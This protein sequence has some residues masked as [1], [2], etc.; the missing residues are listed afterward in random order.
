MYNIHIEGSSRMTKAEFRSTLQ[1][2]DGH[3]VLEMRS[4]FSLT[5]EWAAH[6]ALFR[7]GLWKQRTESVDL[8]APQKWWMT[9][10][11]ILTGSFVWPFIK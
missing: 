7:L 6:K 2:W 4:R 3:P 1:K 5:M 8:D 10:A 9:T 11:Y